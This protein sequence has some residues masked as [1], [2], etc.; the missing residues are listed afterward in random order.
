MGFQQVQAQYVNAVSNQMK[1]R[2]RQKRDFFTKAEQ[3]AILFYGA[4]VQVLEGLKPAREREK[5]FTEDLHAENPD[6]RGSQLGKFPT[7]TG[8]TE[9]GTPA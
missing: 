7:D 3:A 2:N 4:A 6:M 9:P 8:H 5:I 1:R